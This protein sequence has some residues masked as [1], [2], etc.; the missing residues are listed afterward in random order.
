MIS[1]PGFTERYVQL[2]EIQWEEWSQ[3]GDLLDSDDQGAAEADEHHIWTQADDPEGDGYLVYPGR[4][5]VN[6]IGYFIAQRPWDDR[7]MFVH[8][9]AC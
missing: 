5:L 1:A 7:Q 6:G 2:T 9:P 8:I 3:P 4:R